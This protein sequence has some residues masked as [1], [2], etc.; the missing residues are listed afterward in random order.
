M[1]V[2]IDTSILID[3]LRGGT[4]WKE[5]IITAPREAELFLPTIVIFELYCGQSSKKQSTKDDMT[6]LFKKFQQIDINDRIAKRAGELYR[7]I[8][9]HISAQDYII[10]A[11]AL[12][13]GATVVTL[14]TR[15]FEKIPNLQIYPL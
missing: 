15:H 10:G 4:K 5:F 13:I 6:S 9:K 7:D 14:N 1:N 3:Y 11:S 2:V 12:E 8:G